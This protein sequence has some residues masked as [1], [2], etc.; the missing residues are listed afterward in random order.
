VPF[1]APTVPE[2]CAMVLKEPP[3]PLRELRPDVS[4]ELEAVVQRCL[5]KDPKDRFPDVAELARALEAAVGADERMS[6]EISA[7]V[8]AVLRSSG[9]QV[10]PAGSESIVDA[11][12]KTRTASSWG[13]GDAQ[14][15]KFKPLRFLGA[16]SAVAVGG[17]AAMALVRHGCLPDP[18]AREVLGKEIAIPSVPPAVQPAAASAPT[19]SAPTSPASVSGAPTADAGTERAAETPRPAVAASTRAPKP[20]STKSPITATPPAPTTTQAKESNPFDRP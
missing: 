17:I 18:A 20:P 6:R 19:A 3:R 14:R 8:H 5:E 13:S 4:P 15:P 12:A 16:L 9:P 1:D 11:H 10:K 7:R 2:I